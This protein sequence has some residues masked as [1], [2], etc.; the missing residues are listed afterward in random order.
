MNPTSLGDENYY[1]EEK[2][3]NEENDS[4]VGDESE[5]DSDE[6]ENESE[7]E[8][9]IM[10]G[11][12]DESEGYDE[13]EEEFGVEEQK[14]DIPKE[15]YKSTTKQ[16]EEILTDN[17]DEDEDENYLM[18]FDKEIRKNYLVDFHPETLTN[19]YSEI[20]SLVNITRDD[21]GVIIDAFHKTLPFLT[22]Y[23]KTRVIGQ[24]TKQINS[25]SKP[26]INV[27]VE[28]KDKRMIDGNLIAMKE[29]ELKKIPFIIRR[30]LPNG[31]SEYWR[32][33]DLDLLG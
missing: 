6:S 23:E 20:Q 29:L 11:G 4:I 2:V 15:I 17:E 12:G 21:R 25:G 28:F 7:S 32:L 18:K 31:S 22:K 10:K 16:L 9:I 3:E 5:S 8:K 19:N 26:Y 14:E 13:D 24:R 30:P 27:S 33:E 1:P